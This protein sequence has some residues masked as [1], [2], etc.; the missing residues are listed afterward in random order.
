MNRLLLL[1]F[2]LSSTTAWAQDRPLPPQEAPKAMTLPAGF[3]AT[4]FAGEPDVVQPIAFTFDD[5]GRLWVVECLSYPKWSL[6]RTGHDRVVIFEDTDGDGRFDKKTVFWDKGS[7]LTGIEIGFGGVWLCSTPDLIFIPNEN[8]KPGTP[9][10]VL[11]GWDLKAQHNVFNGLTWGPDGWLWDCNGILSNSKVGKPGTPDDKRVPMNCGVWRYHPTRGEFEVVAH[12]TTNPWGLDFDDYGQAFIT[13]CVIH[14][15]WHV[16]P[17]AHFQRMFGQDLNPHTYAL[18]PSIADHIHW[19]GGDWTSSR[20]GKGAHDAPGGG[21]AHS[22]CM[23]YLGD[24]F[25]DEYRNSAFMCNIHGNRINRDILKPRGSTYVASHGPDFLMAN[26]PWFRGIAVKYGP[27]GGVYV[28]DWTDTGECH[29]Y[30]V[31]DQTNGRIYKITYGQPKI[32][33]GDLAQLSDLGLAKLQTHKNDWMVRHA[34]RLLQERA[35]VGKVD[36]MAVAELRQALTTATDTAKRLRGLWTL[37]AIG[38]FSDADY[39]LT[40]F[41]RNEHVRAWAINLAMERRNPTLDVFKNCLKL[42]EEDPSPVIRLALAG[43]LPRFALHEQTLLALRLCSQPNDARDYYLPLMEWYAVDRLVTTQPALAAELLAETKVA[44]VRQFL[45]RRLIEM[46]GD[47][48][49]Q[50]QRLNT[51]LRIA[52]ASD[53]GAQLPLIRGLV[54]SLAGQRF[55]K[56][57]QA[58]NDLGPIPYPPTDETQWLTLELGVIF[59]DPHV[60]PTL[61]TRLEF[62]IDPLDSRRRELQA[63]MRR[64]DEKLQALLYDLL[65][66]GIMKGEVVRSLAALPADP[67]TPKAILG[68]Y[69]DLTD[70]EKA[71]AIQTLISRPAYAAALL[72]AVEKGT[73]PRKDISPVAARQILSMKNPQLSER[74]AK[75]WGTIRPASKQRAELTAKYKAILAPDE[76]KKADAVQGKAVFAKTCATCHKLFGDGASIGP[77]LT[78]S[79]RTNLDYIL[80][81]VLDP[82]AVVPREYQ[83]IVFELKNGRTL[84]GIVMQETERAVT[85]QTQNEKIVVAKDDIE[86]R[87]QTNVSMMP[88]GLFD[89]LSPQEVRNLVAYLM[90]PGKK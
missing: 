73:V 45:T 53:R 47:A 74:L 1:T 12:G 50:D 89:S 68:V 62:S 17:G 82:S 5:R 55:D 19:G 90:G 42:A 63:L 70:N 40:I 18:M 24:N 51:V 16:V 67:R 22:G 4:L 72:D 52:S 37:H 43:A 77:E 7:N 27:D 9:K 29:N 59:N 35:A 57:P 28:S 64:P 15:I 41:D 61:R 81:N 56:P 20:G 6:D 14:H 10:V 39:A 26:D 66:D 13:N 38:A 49:T 88:E 23:I 8:D 36:P 30:Q 75:V 86:S 76:L 11:D 33:P 83:V 25:P 2:F 21:H 32:I 58:W 71:D 87:T 48:Q 78:G 46:P 44:V 79:Q 65:S 60:L 85:V 80:E 69:G 3:K 34:R 54:E 84:N 31:V